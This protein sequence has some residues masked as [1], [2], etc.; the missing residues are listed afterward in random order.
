MLYPVILVPGEGTMSSFVSLAETLAAKGLFC[1]LYTDRGSHY[2]DTPKA[3]GKIAK[4]ASTQFGRALCQLGIEHNCRLLAASPRALRANVCDAGG[5]SAQGEGATGPGTGNPM[6][7]H[8][9]RDVG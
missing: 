3:G 4:G 1:S 5:P 7:H 8:G 9:N 2:F 6:S